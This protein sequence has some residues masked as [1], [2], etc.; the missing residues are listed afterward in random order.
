M[1]TPPPH[2]QAAIAAA[3]AAEDKRMMRA[4][5][6]KARDARCTE[7]SPILYRKAYQQALLLA[8]RI[9]SSP[10]AGYQA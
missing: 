1:M 3:C 6:A 9:A 8:K 7:A 10:D 4:R 2:I 5:E